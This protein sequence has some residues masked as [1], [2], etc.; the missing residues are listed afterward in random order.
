M[1]DYDLVI[2]GGTVVTPSDMFRSDIGIAHGRIQA[3][4]F[5]LT[6]ARTLDADGMLVMPGGV[7]THCHI[8]QLRADGSTDEETFVTGSTS[9]LAG[10]TTS[11]IT[12][13]TQFKGQGISAPPTM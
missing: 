3:I 4:G 13:S 6:G 5:G 7:D 9:A 1:S 11:V 12:F 8:E 10:G 2:A